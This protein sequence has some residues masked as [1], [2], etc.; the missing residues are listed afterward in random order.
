MVLDSKF[1]GA[2]V[3][4][5]SLVCSWHCAKFQMPDSGTGV[6]A[7]FSHWLSRFSLA[8]VVSYRSK[9]DDQIERLRYEEGATVIRQSLQESRMP[10]RDGRRQWQYRLKL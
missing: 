5:I 6:P 8:L 3:R 1:H 10:L 4:D 2:F 7:L 9:L